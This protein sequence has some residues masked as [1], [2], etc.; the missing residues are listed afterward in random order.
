MVIDEPQLWQ[1]EKPIYLGEF[2]IGNLICWEFCDCNVSYCP[3]AFEIVNLMLVP[4]Y[5]SGMEDLVYASWRRIYWIKWFHKKSIME[6]L[7]L[8]QM[9]LIF[10][11]ADHDLLKCLALLRMKTH[12]K[13]VCATKSAIRKI[14]YLGKLPI[15]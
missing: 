10:N 14:Q 4:Y 12:V 8:M 7:P 2:L 5:V 3:S 6:A 11:E 1:Q 9:P 15:S 13:L